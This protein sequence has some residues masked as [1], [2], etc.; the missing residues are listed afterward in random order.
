MHASLPTLAIDEFQAIYEF[1]QSVRVEFQRSSEP[2]SPDS[3][4]PANVLL[5]FIM[6]TVCFGAP[7]RYLRYISELDTMFLRGDHW[8]LHIQRLVKEWTDANLLVGSAFT[9][10]C[11][12]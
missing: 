11:P 7:F 12:R 6:T 5:V 2:E 3:S 4:T 10:E 9:A 1:G 8:R